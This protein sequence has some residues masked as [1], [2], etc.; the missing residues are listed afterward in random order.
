M[1]ANLDML[2]QV[3]TAGLQYNNWL[4]SS[5]ILQRLRD[6]LGHRLR[7]IKK[8]IHQRFRET[9]KKLC[10][11]S[12]AQKHLQTILFATCPAIEKEIYHVTNFYNRK[13]PQIHETSI[14]MIPLAF[15][16]HKQQTYLLSA[17]PQ[18]APR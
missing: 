12:I 16:M 7:A 5:N 18:L 8:R 4:L 9:C 11:L 6:G 1:N 13:G 14:K 15:E 2:C 17:R 3:S 10:V